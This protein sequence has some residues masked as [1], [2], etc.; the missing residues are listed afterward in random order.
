MYTRMVVM[1]VSWRYRMLF[2]ANGSMSTLVNVDYIKWI[3]FCVN[4]FSVSINNSIFSGN[5]QQKVY[6][7][8]CIGCNALNP[9]R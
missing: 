2:D 6:F 1:V 3:Y 8:I 7:L 9:G 5:E 4:E